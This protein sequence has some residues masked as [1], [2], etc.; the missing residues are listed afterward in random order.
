MRQLHPVGQWFAKQ[1]MRHKAVAARRNEFICPDVAD[2][3]VPPGYRI[4][5]DPDDALPWLDSVTP[6]RA[7]AAFNRRAVIVAMLLCMDD[8]GRIVG[9]H[10]HFAD[11]AA[12][13]GAHISRTCA[14]DHVRAL[15]RAGVLM[16]AQ[17]GCSKEINGSGRDW[18]PVYVVLA[19]DR[20]S[21]EHQALV[22]AWEKAQVSDETDTTPEVSVVK[23]PDRSSIG[24]CGG[25]KS[26]SMPARR[27]HP[28]RYVPRSSRERGLGNV[29]FA[30]MVGVDP[31]Y[32]CR[33]LHKSL[34]KFYRRGW[35]PAAAAYAATH[36]RDGEFD[37]S[38]IRDADRP[39][40]LVNWRLSRW[41][42]EH[43][44]PVA[45]PLPAQIPRRGPREPA[46]VPDPPDQLAPLHPPRQRGADADAEV[47][48]LRAKLA[49]R[50]TVAAAR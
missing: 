2:I 41:C 13:Q 50:R 5:A 10:Q 8:Q 7:D 6:P 47:A 37:E 43:G 11:L 32:H 26:P 4:A 17:R 33:D 19:P 12:R 30:G 25:E 36:D 44:E 16:V 45:P 34:T 35:T 39:M 1:V 46:T 9:G 21:A 28:D 24:Q 15:E 22:D 20:L 49:A 23:V 27:E 14:G 42:N 31:D 18:A 3:R 40:R 48:A 29:W 38:P